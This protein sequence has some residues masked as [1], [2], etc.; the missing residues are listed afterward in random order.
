MINKNEYAWED[1]NI[2]IKNKVVEG[3][4][5][6]EY[7]T[8]KEHFDIMGRGEDPV[9]L[10]KGQKGYSGQMTLLQSEVEALQKLM[11]AGKDITNMAPFTITVGYTPDDAA[12]QATFDQLTSVRITEIKK[13]YKNTDGFMVCDIPL[14]IGKINYNI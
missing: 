7:T 3:I 11:P 2:V 9:A 8:Q 5:G 6:I 14:K 13:A 10:G 12:A 1:I 4:Q